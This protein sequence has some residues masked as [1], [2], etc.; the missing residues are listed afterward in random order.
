VLIGTWNLA[1]QWSM[2]H[3]RAIEDADCDI[4]LLTDVPARTS[5]NGYH[6]HLSVGRRGPSAHWS[7]ILSRLAAEPVRHTS[8][9]ATVLSIADIVIVSTVLPWPEP[10]EDEPWEGASHAERYATALTE[11]GTLLRGHIPIWGGTWNQPL[12]GN[13]IG[14]SKQAQAQL[15]SFVSAHDLQ[16][17][18]RDLLGRQR[19]YTTD[20]IAVPASWTV[21]DS[22]KVEVDA[23][24]S[25]YDLFCV[26]ATPMA[27]EV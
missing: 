12:M 14:Y 10:H 7:G 23:G 19:Q 2:D 18:T 26:E 22:G 17:P 27:P 15:E 20:H 3:A 8:P 24:L 16:V 5:V 9:T 1:G 21:I 11:T 13:I 4:W 25:P 6:Q